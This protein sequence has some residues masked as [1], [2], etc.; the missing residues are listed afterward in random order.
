[1]LL[2]FRKIKPEGSFTKIKIRILKWYSETGVLRTG[3]KL[4]W[5]KKKWT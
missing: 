4:Y 5:W 1:M 3:R 2:S